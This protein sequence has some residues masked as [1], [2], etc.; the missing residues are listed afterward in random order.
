M[1]RARQAGFRLN[2]PDADRERGGA[3]I[4][5]VPNGEAVSR[6]L[7]DQ[8]II[9]DHRPGAGVRMAPHF[10]NSEEEIDRAMDVLEAIVSTAAGRKS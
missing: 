5:D 2:T 3:V 7:L 8:G 9:I 4:V 10:Y 6:E 1:D